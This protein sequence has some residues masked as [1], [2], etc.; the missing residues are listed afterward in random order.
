MGQS[1]TVHFYSDK[2]KLITANI[3]HV[4]TAYDHVD[5]NECILNVNHGFHLTEDHEP[6]RSTQI[7]YGRLAGSGRCAIASVTIFM[8]QPIRYS[9]LNFTYGCH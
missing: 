2:Y 6:S 3:A 4:G 7:N 9:S 1:C 5:G 8:P